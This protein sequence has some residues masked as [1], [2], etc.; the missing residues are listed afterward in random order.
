MEVVKFE[1]MPRLMAELIKSNKALTKEISLIKEG[2]LERK[3]KGQLLKGYNGIK[4]HYKFGT[5]K[6]NKL[7]ASGAPIFQVGR[8][9]HCYSNELDDFISKNNKLN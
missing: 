8:T 5:D 7:M 2:L 9:L 1:D 6:I 4:A 3:E